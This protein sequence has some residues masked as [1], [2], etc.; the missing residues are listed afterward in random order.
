MSKKWGHG[1]CAYG[2]ASSSSLCSLAARV[3]SFLASPPHPVMGVF[4]SASCQSFMC[5]WF[6]VFQELKAV[7]P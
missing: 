3:H 6:P 4:G 2:Q 5:A 1:I 7:L